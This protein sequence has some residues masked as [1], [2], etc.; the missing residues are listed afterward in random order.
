MWASLRRN[1]E[2][3]ADWCSEADEK[4]LGWASQN[5]NRQEWTCGCSE[6]DERGPL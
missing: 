5:G 6:A 1:I 4:A 3:W 2:K